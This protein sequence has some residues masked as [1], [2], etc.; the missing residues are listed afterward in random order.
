V[1]AWGLV[2]ED[3]DY[4]AVECV[5]VEWF[6]R[7]TWPPD[8]A[9]LRQRVRTR[10]RDER[11]ARESAA[12]VDGYRPAL[13]E[14]WMRRATRPTATN[15][16]ITQHVVELAEAWRRGDIGLDS[17]RRQ[18]EGVFDMAGGYARF[19]ANHHAR[20]Q[21][22]DLIEALAAEDDAREGIIRTSFGGFTSQDLHEHGGIVSRLDGR[23]RLV[24]PVSGAGPGSWRYKPAGGA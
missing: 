11:V 1:K 8:P 20:E 14:G 5:L 2:L 10:E 4:E 3:V 21:V 13:G 19:V 9:E 17:V 22:K 24:W 18:C 6:R 15:L 7:E 12:L 16:E 23:A